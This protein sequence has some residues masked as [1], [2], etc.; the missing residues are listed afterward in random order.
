MNN[1]FSTAVIMFEYIT[2]VKTH[3]NIILWDYND[4][5]GKVLVMETQ[6]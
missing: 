3:R 4:T 1:N 5:W 6:C 2:Y